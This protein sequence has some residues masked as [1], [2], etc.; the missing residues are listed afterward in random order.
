MSSTLAKSAILVTISEIVFNVT[1][2]LVHVVVGR[3]LGPADYGRF[4]LV[5]TLTTMVIILIGNGIPTAMSKYLSEIF[6]TQ[7]AL[8]KVIKRQAIILQSILIGA[9]TLIFFFSA[10][11]IAKILGDPTLTPLF[12]LSTL[13]IPAFAAASFYFSYYTGLHKFGVQSFLKISRSLFRVIFIISLAFFFRLEG[14]VMGYIAAPLAVFLLAAGIDRFKISKE[15][16]PAPVGAIHESPLQ[17]VA[18]SS[19]DWKKL[20]SYA[21]QIIVFFLAYELLISIDLYL[22]KGIIQND[23]LTGVYNA[24]LTLG[25]FP[26]YL[27]YALTVILLPVVS[28]TTSENN[29]KDTHKVIS[30]SLR[31]MLVLLS[32]IVVL[33]SVYSLPLIK[34]FYGQNFLE[35]AVPMSILVFGVGFLTIF[36]VMS[37]VMNG[38]GH[39]KIPMWI[40]TFGLVANTVLNY[41]LIK[42]YGIVGSA[43]ATTAVSFLIML[44]MLYY[45]GKYFGVLVGFKSLTKIIFASGAIYAASLFSPA[46]NYIF[47]LWSLIFTLAYFS[48][49]FAAGEIKKEDLMFLKKSILSKSKSKKKNP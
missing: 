46:D 16:Q 32:P 5:V 37:F 43:I 19:F 10:P 22:V 44:V 35:A 48:I 30:Q 45:I 2:F 27:F 38:A 33:M 3:I 14:S 11:L 20:I 1:S 34:L 26:Y 31:L 17:D 42:Q 25:R 23:Y 41:I 24:S 18:Q 8:I 39:T 49:L 13:I 29:H 12:R 36:Y 47:I 21:W 15:L 6:E 40:A 4:G 7:P 9:I 28:K